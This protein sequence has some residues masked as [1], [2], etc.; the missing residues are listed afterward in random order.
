MIRFAHQ[1]GHRT[2]YIGHRVLFPKPYTLSPK[3]T[4]RSA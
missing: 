4:E 2:K 1:K 3:A